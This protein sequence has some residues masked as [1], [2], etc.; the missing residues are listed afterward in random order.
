M[1]RPCKATNPRL[2]AERTSKQK[3]KRVRDAVLRAHGDK[4]CQR[5]ALD[6]AKA[7]QRGRV[8]DAVLRAHGDK[9]RQ[10]KALDK[11]KADEHRRSRYASFRKDGDLIAIQRSQSAAALKK[12]KRG[13]KQ[14]RRIRSRSV[15][16][17]YKAPT[18]VTGMREAFWAQ[19]DTYKAGMYMYIY[20]LYF[21]P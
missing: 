19:G 14:S 15:V 7:K 1:G 10:R 18:T 4:D 2:R 11:A 13:L 9:Y 12:R 3:E 17:A 21:V 16:P 5:K 8:R 6:E 20:R